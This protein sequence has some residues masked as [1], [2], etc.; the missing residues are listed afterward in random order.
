MK[1]IFALVL[2]LALALSL[3]VCGM[4]EAEL[5]EWEQKANIYATD[6][7]D[8]E[9]TNGGNDGKDNDG[10]G[11]VDEPGENGAGPYRR[12][13]G[14]RAFVRAARRRACKTRGRASGSEGAHI[15]ALENSLY[16]CYP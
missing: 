11:D 9:E 13:R 4:A 6:E 1:K 2:A 3:A 15:L 5:T 10:D 7:T 14:A 8:E 16:P 12:R